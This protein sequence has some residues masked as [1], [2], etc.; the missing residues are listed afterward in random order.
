VLK[1]PPPVKQ[2]LS[3]CWAAALASW[4]AAKTGKKPRT[5]RSLIELY[6]FDR[7]RTRRSRCLTPR[8]A[9]CDDQAAREVFGEWGVA[10]EV[11][12]G[13]GLRNVTHEQLTALLRKHR[14]LLLVEQAV[15]PTSG[16]RSRGVNHVTVLYGVG[17]N[18]RKKTEKHWFSVMDPL[19]SKP[20]Y[21]NRYLGSLRYPVWIGYATGKS[22]PARCVDETECQQ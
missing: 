17:V 1:P 2:E 3:T 21:Q 16:S 5:V 11:H 14:H 22:V 4:V 13:G 18:D 12:R 19:P 9:L 6:A 15:E 20:T 10:F 7:E 8:W